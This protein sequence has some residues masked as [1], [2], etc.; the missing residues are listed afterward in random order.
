[1]AINIALTGTDVGFSGWEVSRFLK[2]E[3]TKKLQII[4]WFLKILAEPGNAGAANPGPD[5]LE[6]GGAG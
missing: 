2:P 3:Q 1:M 4:F 6:P 5:H